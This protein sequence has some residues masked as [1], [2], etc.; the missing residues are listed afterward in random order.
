VAIHWESRPAWSR[1]HAFAGAW[2]LE[3]SERLGLEIAVQVDDRPWM[4]WS[5]R[6][7][8]PQLNTS[9]GNEVSPLSHWMLLP[10]PVTAGVRVRSLVNQTLRTF[11]SGRRCVHGQSRRAEW[12]GRV[13]MAWGMGG[14]GARGDSQSVC[15]VTCDK[16]MLQHV[17]ASVG[18]YAIFNVKGSCANV[19]DA[20]EWLRSKTELLGV[21]AAIESFVQTE[22]KRGAQAWLV[23]QMPR[24]VLWM[25]RV[26]AV[27]NLT[28]DGP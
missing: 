20:V 8:T 10:G 28:N 4:A 3:T 18:P 2:A 27:C 1:L 19:P 25:H 22:C 7:W 16:G 15:S 12:V 5:R 17:E 6:D 24:Q 9:F 11:A 26:E 13:D 23:P 21:D 14:A